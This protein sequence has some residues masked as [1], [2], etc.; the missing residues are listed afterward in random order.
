M[1]TFCLYYRK[2][3]CKCACSKPPCSLRSLLFSL[4]SSA[5]LF[6]LTAHPQLTQFN[7][8]VSFIDKAVKAFVFLFFFSTCIFWTH[9]LLFI[10]CFTKEAL[11]M[12]FC[13][14]YSNLQGVLCLLFPFGSFL[15]FFSG[16]TLITMKH[17]ERTVIWTHIQVIFRSTLTN[18]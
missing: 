3:I 18:F 11:F 10:L 9:M 5:F 16:F 4:L 12:A 8:F 14:L 13:G 1:N 17:V 2:V 7:L 6:F 15:F